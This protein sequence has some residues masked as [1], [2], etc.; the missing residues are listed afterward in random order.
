M[1]FADERFDVAV[2]EY[3]AEWPHAFAVIAE[4]LRAADRCPR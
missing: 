1:P 4:E 3:R 2:V